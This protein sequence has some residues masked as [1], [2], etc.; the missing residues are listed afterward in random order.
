MTSV[1]AAS[2]DR[3]L[4]EVSED[5]LVLD[6]GGW[7]FFDLAEHDAWLDAPIRAHAG[8]LRGRRGRF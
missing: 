4:T 7:I 8:E 3:L 6:V 5:A 2:F 1:L